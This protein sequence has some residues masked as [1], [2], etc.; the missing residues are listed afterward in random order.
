MAVDSDEGTDLSSRSARSRRRW[1]K[2]FWIIVLIL[3]LAGTIYFVNL[4]H[5]WRAEFHRRI[6]AIRAAGCPVT[7]KE[8]DAWY[9]W[10]Q[11]GENAAGWITGAATLHH[12]LRQE[13]SRLLE[14]IVS[15]SGERPD[16]NQPLPEDIG[17]LL[18]RYV[19]EN[20][21]AL[22]MLHGATSFVEC[23]YPIDLSQG[24]GVGMPHIADVREGCLL[25][26]AEAVLCA[27][28]GDPNGATRA[29]E[30]ALHVACSLD[31]EPIMLS[32]LVYM[33]GV[34]WAAAALEWV[35]NAVPFTEE[36]LARLHRAFSGIHANDALLRAVMGDRCLLLGAF[37][38]PKVLSRRRFSKVPP[39][40]L[41]EV[42]DAVGLAAREGIIFLDY[43]DECLRIA[44]LPAFQRPAAIG[45]AEAHY[46]RSRKGVL[47][48]L[49]DTR[50][51]PAMIGYELKHVAQLEIARTLL[52]VERYRLAHGSLPKTLDQLVPGC[53]AAVPEDPF[54]GAPLRYKRLHRGFLVYSVGEDRTDD[55][56]REEPRKKQGETYDLVFRVER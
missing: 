36:Q 12:K 44:H 14:R 15:R 6:E 4:R 51:M 8:L 16:P 41:L 56:G 47:L 17:D 38:K 24:S 32:H 33:E 54:D 42:Y 2:W 27:E 13:Y 48:G 19:R 39:I 34:S 49:V 18:E 37:E 30:A 7:G 43:L 11:G 28:E 9:P 31:Q 50:S 21:K 22:E 3:P 45:A 1:G 20:V 5:H 26:C 35:L 53:L 40:A 55:G 29:I 25:L 10:P 46:G 52:V 23:R